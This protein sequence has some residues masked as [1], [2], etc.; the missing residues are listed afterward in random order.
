VSHNREKAN[1]KKTGD[2]EKKLVG[3][4]WLRW[5]GE[6]GGEG[7]LRNNRVEDVE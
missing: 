7:S 6:H 4:G 2:G 3:N 1:T 5:F